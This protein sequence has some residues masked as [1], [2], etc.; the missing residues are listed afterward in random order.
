LEKAD[1]AKTAFVSQV[2]HEL[3]TP[4]HGMLSHVELLRDVVKHHH[5]DEA[6]ALLETAE[7]CGLALRDILENVLES[8]K[9]IAQG[10]TSM[11]ANS[12]GA[13]LEVDLRELVVQ[14]RSF[15]R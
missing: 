7:H 12:L 15:R 14:V 9:I 1:A 2:S 13:L 5:L 8:S 4:L 10:A 11:E 6:T 3:R